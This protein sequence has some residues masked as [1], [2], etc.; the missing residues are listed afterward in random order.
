MAHSTFRRKN[1]VST[2]RYFLWKSIPLCLWNL[3]FTTS[4]R[5]ASLTANMCLDHSGQVRVPAILKSLCCCRLVVHHPEWAFNSW[6]PKI[7]IVFKVEILWFIQWKID[8]KKNSGNFL[9]TIN[10]DGLNARPVDRSLQ[11]SPTKLPPSFR[12]VNPS[13]SSQSTTHWYERI[14][15]SNWPSRLWSYGNIFKRIAIRPL[16]K[17]LSPLFPVLIEQ[18]NN[19]RCGL[20]DCYHS[21]FKLIFSISVPWIFCYF[22]KNSYKTQTYLTIC[23]LGLVTNLLVFWSFWCWDVNCHSIYR[24]PWLLNAYSECVVH[25]ALEVRP[26]LDAWW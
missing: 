19:A 16:I 24:G 5:S 1:S 7:Y 21:L 6:L 18:S 8:P 2:K 3:V 11:L 9:Y 17:S 13:N 14:W 12:V 4:L 25:T 10:L 22:W 20:Q 15:V 26:P 23:R